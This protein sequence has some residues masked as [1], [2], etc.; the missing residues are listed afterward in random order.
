MAVTLAGTREAGSQAVV[1]EL[2]E[3]RDGEGPATLIGLARRASVLDAALIN[4][5]AAHALDY[6]DVSLP[7]SAHASVVILPALL[8]LAEKRKA[9][10][11]QVL[12]SFV[13]GYEAGARIGM[14]MAPTHYD[15]GFHGTGTIGTFAAAAACAHLMG[16]DADRTER[17]IGIAAAQAA[18]IRSMFGTD[19]KPLH[20][21]KGAFNG[22]FSALLAARDFTSAA[23]SIECANGFAAT[24]SG[25]CDG[26][27]AFA[28][29]PGGYFLRQNLFKYHAACYMTHAAANA[30]TESMT[31]HGVDADLVEHVGVTVDESLN[32]VC[33]IARP[34]SGLEMKFSLRTV[35]ALALL[36]RD[37]SRLSSF[38]D[39][40]VSDAQLSAAREKVEVTLSNVR[41]ITRSR[42]HLHLK[43]GQSFETEHDSGRPETNL[44]V[45]EARLQRKFQALAGEVLGA[46]RAGQ[47]LESID[48]LDTPRDISVMLRLASQ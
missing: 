33:N 28:E 45:Q 6:D 25:A 43:G 35:A 22:L 24:H 29:P 9:S 13:A 23:G 4:G 18:G 30:I 48:T 39:G 21:G 15:H 10:G 12:E 41:P 1:A 2:L 20:A 14:Y 32:G 5:V 27:A 3:D 42:V 47:L 16:L 19:C 7:M 40:A 46:A 17:A 36:G 11:R 38:S 34:V 44:A 37:T 8:A 26:T 31:E